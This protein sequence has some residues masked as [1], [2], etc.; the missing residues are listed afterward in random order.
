MTP[1]NT[2]KQ[3]EHSSNNNIICNTFWEW[4]CLISSKEVFPVNVGLWFFFWRG[5]GRGV[6]RGTSIKIHFL[7]H[8]YELRCTYLQQIPLLGVSSWLEQ[9]CYSS[10][11]AYSL[12]KGSDTE[13]SRSVC[14]CVSVNGFSVP[15]LHFP[16]VAFLKQCLPRSLLQIHVYRLSWGGCGHIRSRTGWEQNRT[17]SKLFQRCGS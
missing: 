9:R 11:C 14:L 3:A 15:F 5:M 4:S 17:W 10:T 12:Q 7:T 6:S 16:C 2:L 13:H 1:L 8:R